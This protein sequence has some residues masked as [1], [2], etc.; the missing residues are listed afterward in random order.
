MGD[1]GCAPESV[2]WEGEDF[3]EDFVKISRAAQRS[4]RHCTASGEPRNTWNTRNGQFRWVL[5]LIAPICH[6]PSPIPNRTDE[7]PELA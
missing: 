7:R 4:R 6:L 3:G 2:S 5:Q 1:R